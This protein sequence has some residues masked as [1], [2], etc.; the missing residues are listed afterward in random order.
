MTAQHR[1]ASTQNRQ[2]PSPRVIAGRTFRRFSRLAP[3]LIVIRSW[4]DRLSPFDH[5]T[6]VALNG[7][8]TRLVARHA[9]MKD[10]LV[11][12]DLCIATFRALWST[13]PSC[14]KRKR[15]AA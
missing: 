10:P 5:V 14:K 4:A 3:E 11:F 2:L 7:R 13:P 9:A 6:Y 12:S 1:T 8:L 15:E